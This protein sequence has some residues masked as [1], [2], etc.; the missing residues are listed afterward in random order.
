MWLRFTSLSLSLGFSSSTSSCSS[1][2]FVPLSFLTGP[3]GDQQDSP[4]VQ[5]CPKGRYQAKTGSWWGLLQLP[6][7]W[8]ALPWQGTSEHMCQTMTFFK[9]NICIFCKAIQLICFWIWNKKNTR[10][11][12]CTKRLRPPSSTTASISSVSTRSSASACG[13]STVSEAPPSAPLWSSS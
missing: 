13:C 3:W 9:K 11:P 10:W 4:G 6:E 2:P 12:F 8:S 7:V 1:Y 5:I